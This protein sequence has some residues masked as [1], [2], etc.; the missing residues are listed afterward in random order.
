MTDDHLAEEIGQFPPSDLFSTQP[1]RLRELEKL[2]RTVPP[3][4]FDLDSWVDSDLNTGENLTPWRE[5][6][7]YREC[8]FAGCAVGWAS[9]HQPFRDQGLTLQYGC[10]KVVIGDEYATQWAAVK[11]FFGIR[12]E[13]HANYLFAKEE[14]SHTD[15]RKTSPIEVADRIAAVLKDGFPPFE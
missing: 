1:D 14:Y 8:G 7:K 9:Q 11:F 10:P 15:G 5:G 2:L 4:R 12:Y 6:T 13:T 3:E